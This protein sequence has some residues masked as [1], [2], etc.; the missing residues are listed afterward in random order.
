MRP[1]WIWIISFASLLVV[2]AAWYFQ[3]KR[4][5][6]VHQIEDQLRLRTPV[7]A[8]ADQVM[9]VLDSMKAEHSDASRG[10]ISA[11]FGKSFE[12]AQVYAA[13]YGT[14]NLDSHRRLTSYKVDE[15]FTGP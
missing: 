2:A 14:F 4:Y 12:S 5:V 7:G 8:S 9:A 1:R 6:T 10:V 3:P 15:L 13:I 11:N